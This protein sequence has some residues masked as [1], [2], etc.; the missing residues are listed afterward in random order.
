MKTI[1]IAINGD[2]VTYV[3]AATTAP[4]EYDGFGTF[5]LT[6]IDADVNGR[7]ARDGKALRVV[8]IRQEHLQWQTMRYHSGNEGWAT[9]ADRFDYFDPEYFDVAPLLWTRLQGLS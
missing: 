5:T 1:T 3:L 8:L 2:T 9:V 6:T 4:K 7:A